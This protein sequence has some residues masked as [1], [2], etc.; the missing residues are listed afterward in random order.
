MPSLMCKI[1]HTACT[2]AFQLSTQPLHRLRS[3]GCVSGARAQLSDKSAR[4]ECTVP[5]R[6]A[7]WGFA[8]G[9]VCMRSRT[10]V[11]VLYHVCTATLNVRHFDFEHLDTL[12]SSF[13]I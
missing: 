3:G 6:T 2:I 10:L 13:N 12:A 1:S 7:R 11:F 9:K 5:S 8:R 4:A